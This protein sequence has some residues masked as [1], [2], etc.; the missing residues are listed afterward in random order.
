[1]IGR[2]RGVVAEKRP[3]FLLLEV[4][5]VGYELEAPMST[6]YRLPPVGGE[7]VLLTHLVVRDDAQQ[8]FGFATAAERDL[9]RALI[10]VSGVGA[11][12]ALAILSGISAEAFARCVHEGDSA[13][14]V[15]LP[16][17]GR[18]TAERLIVEMRDRIAPPGEAA[19]G[20]GG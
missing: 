12:M 18:K 10:R 11:K 19:E 1:M 15:R 2:L 17:I 7:A 6:F 3:P 16:G 8:L 20:T 5:G 13:A 9:F 4:G 14:L